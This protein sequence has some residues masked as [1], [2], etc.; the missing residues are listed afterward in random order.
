MT[1]KSGCQ[2]LV[3][4]GIA[5]ESGGSMGLIL[6]DADDV[7]EKLRAGWTPVPGG[8]E[9]ANEESLHEFLDRAFDKFV[10]HRQYSFAKTRA[11]LVI[12]FE[13]SGKVVVE[14]KANLTDRNEYH[15][16]IGQAY[17]YLTEWNAHV[18]VVLCGECDLSLVKLVGKAIV[19]LNSNCS[20]QARLLLATD[21]RA[22]VA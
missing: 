9:F 2:T 20:Q 3:V 5:R 1:P 15:R 6:D 16:L 11:D 18:V 8:D 10:V 13:G 14:V 4:S 19:F 22:R 21:S 17:A 12:D 7:M